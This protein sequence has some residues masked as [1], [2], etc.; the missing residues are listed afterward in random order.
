M[1]TS[2]T[3]SLIKLASTLMYYSGA[4][5]LRWETN[6]HPHKIYLVHPLFPLSLKPLSYP[7][8][9]VLHFCVLL[10][11][12]AFMVCRLVQV[13]FFQ[14]SPLTTVLQV[15]WNLLSYAMPVLIMINNF[16]RWTHFPHFINAYILF[17][18]NFRSAHFL[19]KHWRNGCERNLKI[20]VTLGMLITV[21]N[22]VLILKFPER[23]YFLTS[24]L[25][26]PSSW[27]S[28]RGLILLL[29]QGWVWFS[30]WAHIFYYCF[31]FF[32]YAHPLV[33]ILKELRYKSCL[34]PQAW[35]L[36]QKRCV[37]MTRNSL[38]SKFVFQNV[39]RSLQLLQAEFNF[40]CRDWLFP[41]HKGVVMMVAIVGI[42]G[43]IR[44][45]PPRSVVMGVTA[46]FAMLYLSLIFWRLGKIRQKSGETLKAWKT[47]AG[48]ARSKGFRKWLRSCLPLRVEIGGFYIVDR[49]TVVVVWGTVFNFTTTLLLST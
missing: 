39:Y 46:T 11:Y 1:L 5:S 22:T 27:R 38:R 30:C 6:T 49:A 31:N 20:M 9:T 15:V 21:Q 37:F 47:A 7:T 12:E 29:L 25:E 16:A 8:L 2:E 3:L 34:Q 24:L 26:S 28:G 36:R 45:P 35:S 48:G 33:F 18:D 19:P 43:A 40:C 32:A 44:L 13:H 41:T 17:W 23:P 4:A 14:A 10:L 42:F